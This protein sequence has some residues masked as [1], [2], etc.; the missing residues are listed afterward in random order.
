MF[1]HKKQK[2]IGKIVNSSTGAH[3]DGPPPVFISRL[4][5]ADENAH[6]ETPGQSH[7]LTINRPS[8]A[9]ALML[10]SSRFKSGKKQF[11]I[12][13][14]RARFPDTCAAMPLLLSPHACMAYFRFLSPNAEERSEILFDILPEMRLRGVFVS[15]MLRFLKKVPPPLCPVFTQGTHYNTGRGKLHPV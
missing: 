3:A 9:G 2:Q 10:R 7:V 1:L 15:P 6:Y 13:P 8:E 5:F 12:M 11:A 14:S 4:L